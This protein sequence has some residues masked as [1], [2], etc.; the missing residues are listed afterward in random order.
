MKRLYILLFIIAILLSLSSCNKVDNKL[1][2]ENDDAIPVINAFINRN[3]NTL[4]TRFIP[5][6]GYERKE[7]GIDTF[8]YY[9][10]N[11]CLKPDC[12]KVLLYNG[13][14]KGNQSVHAAVIDMEIGDRDLQQCADAVIRLIAE[15]QYANEKY[16]EIGFHLTNGF[17]LPYNKWREGYRLVVD[18]NETYLS[19][20]A[21]YDSGYDTFRRYLNMVF[22][23]AGTLSLQNET[24][25]VENMNDIKVG[26]IFIQGGSPGHTV[27][28]VDVAVNQEGNIAFLLAQSYM[29]AQDIHILKNPLYQEDPWYYVSELEDSIKTPQ[30]IF[31]NKSLKSL[32]CLL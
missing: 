7:Y 9:T 31:N 4:E 20:T 26:D 19:K 23:Y 17:Y 11:L 16:D 6:A 13:D 24:Q 27:M 21:S 30:W 1:S 15:Y 22:A 5:P 29:P 18:G 8:T 32:S 2:S 10:R 28:V 3:G 25:F 12:S 14:E